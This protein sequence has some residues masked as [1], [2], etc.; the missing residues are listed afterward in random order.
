MPASARASRKW[1]PSIDAPSCSAPILP[2]KHVL[3]CVQDVALAAQRQRGVQ[4]LANNFQR[5]GHA[6]LAV[7]AK[8]IEEGPADIDALGAEAQRA[9]HVLSR[10]D[11]A[12]HVDLDLVADR[13]G[14]LFQYR[15]GGRRAVKLASAMVGD[16]DGVRAGVRRHDGVFL[17]EDT[18]QDQLATPALL[19]PLDILPRK[20]LVE[21]LVGPCGERSE[22]ADA[23]GMA[24]DVAEGAALGAGHFQAPAGP[25]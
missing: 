6:G 13:V 5:L 7:R 11:A 3:A 8:A 10:A 18:F 25:A 9:Q 12:V 15:D 14:D 1:M 19:D 22:V 23:L 20:L 21:L 2:M 16:D 4:F 17:V 24:D